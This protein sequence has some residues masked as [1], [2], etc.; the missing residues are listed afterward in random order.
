MKLGIKQFILETVNFRHTNPNFL[1]E[2]PGTP[3]EHPVSVNAGLAY[4]HDKK[5]AAVSVIVV[6]D[7]PTAPYTYEVRYIV[8]LTVD[9]DGEPPPADLDRRL[10]VT[11][12]TMAVPFVRELVANLT[13][14]GRFGTTWVA[15][16]NFADAFDKRR[17]VPAEAAP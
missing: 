16:V 9:Y 7:D 12:G 11:G 5:E 17:D 3:A 4:T 10:V 1:A 2:A 14:R 15:P 8:L 6:S 13:S